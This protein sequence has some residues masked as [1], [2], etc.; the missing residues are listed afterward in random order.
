MLNRTFVGDES[1]CTRSHVTS[2][3]RFGQCFTFTQSNPRTGSLWDEAAKD[4]REG[5]ITPNTRQ[6]RLDTK[7]E[8]QQK[9]V[10]IDA[11]F[12][13]EQCTKIVREK[14]H[15]SPLRVLYTIVAQRAATTKLTFEEQ[16]ADV[17]SAHAHTHS[18]QKHTH[19][20]THA[21]IQ[22]PPPCFSHR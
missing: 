18:Q 22:S 8:Q 4:D 3:M 20:R 12:V 6:T 17:K 16:Q 9:C 7:T 2:R 14:N 19:I 1:G 15:K 13:R 10:R 11:H 5:S 21:Q